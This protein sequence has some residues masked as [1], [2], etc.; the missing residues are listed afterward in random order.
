MQR[1]K[2]RVSIAGVATFDTALQ[3]SRP[4]LGSIIDTDPEW[5]VFVYNIPIPQSR[6]KPTN[7]VVLHCKAAVDA[8]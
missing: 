5:L 3:K 4:R 2:L 1:N 6:M 8:D 7:L